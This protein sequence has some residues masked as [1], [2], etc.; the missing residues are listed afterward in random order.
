MLVWDL[1]VLRVKVYYLCVLTLVYLLFNML[2]VN[3]K[4]VQVM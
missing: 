4:D 2:R 1:G 3:I